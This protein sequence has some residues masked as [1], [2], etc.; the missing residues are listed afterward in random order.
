MLNIIFLEGIF[1]ST[2]KETGSRNLCRKY[3]R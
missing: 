3:E 2:K 1:G